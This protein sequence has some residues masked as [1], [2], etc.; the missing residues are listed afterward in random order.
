MHTVQGNLDMLKFTYRYG[1]G[2]YDVIGTINMI[3]RY[4]EGAKVLAQLVFIDFSFAF[5]CIQPSI[6]AGRSERVHNVNTCLIC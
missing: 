3:L 1:R 6:L 2:V 4:L 5:N